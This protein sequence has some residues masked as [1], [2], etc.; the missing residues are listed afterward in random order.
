MTRASNTELFPMQ[1]VMLIGGVAILIYGLIL[2]VWNC[3][4]GVK[5]W[6]I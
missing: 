1:D 2:M 4:A 5:R 6:W 3:K